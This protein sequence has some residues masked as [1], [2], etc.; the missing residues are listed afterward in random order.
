MANIGGSSTPPTYSTAFGTP[1]ITIDYREP[2][3][4]QS[5]NR[6][7]SNLIRPGIYQGMEMA[8]VNTT[9]ARVNIGKYW[10]Q[11]YDLN[12][13]I[14]GVSV[15]NNTSINVSVSP[16]NPYVYMIYGWQNIANSYPEI[17]IAPSISAIQQDETEFGVQAV[18]IGKA[19]FTLG[20][21][22]GFDY[23]ERTRGSIDIDRGNRLVERLNPTEQFHVVN[24]RVWNYG[25]F[26]LG[27]IQY[28]MDNSSRIYSTYTS[29][30]IDDQ[31]FALANGDPIPSGASITTINGSPNRPNLM[32]S[33][34][35]MGSTNSGTV[36][37]V[38]GVNNGDN[39]VT[40]TLN[41]MPGHSH[42]INDPGHSHAIDFDVA[43][44]S[45][46]TNQFYT[47]GINNPGPFGTEL[48]TTGISV[49][50]QG[51]GQSFD[52]R[53]KYITGIPLI[54]VKNMPDPIV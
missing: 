3:V 40:L 20:N 42:T 6:Y 12:G 53:P 33:R 1:K 21:L 15:E 4:S 35:L 13:F 11:L 34:F 52:I 26:H 22:T 24:R 37:I 23:V 10:I 7:L 19:T 36:S 41:E 47:S 30:F 51:G 38:N 44:A 27:G 31:G 39:T 8:I 25:R 46:G 29:N 48:S 50:P 32:D 45:D 2:I 5:F 28:V 54:L 14:L 43:V 49:N 16:L 17:R 18:I 9:T